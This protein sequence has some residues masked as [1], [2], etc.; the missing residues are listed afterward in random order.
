VLNGAI[1]AGYLEIMTLGRNG[2]ESIKRLAKRKKENG[3]RRR[4][5]PK[6]F[7]VRWYQ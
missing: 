1:D 7:G 2:L 5:P 6:R 3:M 4:Q